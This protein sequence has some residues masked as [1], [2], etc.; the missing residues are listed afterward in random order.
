MITRRLEAA[1][2]RE[3]SASSN[4][5]LEGVPEA[6]R[7]AKQWKFYELDIDGDGLLTKEEAAI[8]DPAKTSPHVERFRL[9]DVD[10]NGSLSRKEYVEPADSKLEGDAK[11]AFENTAK[12]EF[13]MFDRDED[14]KLSFEEFCF[15][16]R[17]YLA[18]APKFRR[19]DADHNGRLTSR[20]FLS[21][22]SVSQQFKQRS[23]FFNFDA[24]NDQV[25]D[26]EEYTKRGQG[27]VVSLKN[28]YLARDADGDGRM[29]RAEFYREALG[30]AWEND[31]RKQAE[32]ADVDGDGFFSL[33]E[34]AVTRTGRFAEL[35]ALRDTNGDG[36]LNILEFLALLPK[37]QWPFVGRDFYAADLDADG[38][39][40]LEQEFVEHKKPVADRRT[41]PDPLVALATQRLE[42]I[43]PA[44]QAAD[45]DKDGRLSA[46]EWPQAKIDRLAPE[47][48]GIPFADWD[49][50]KDGFVT[51]EEQKE[52]VELAF[53]VALPGGL[54]LRKP[55]GHVFGSLFF[56]LDANKDGVASREEFI[57]GY[58]EKEKN[59]ERFKE[60]D[61]DGDG[62]LTM[63]EATA[64]AQM[65]TDVYFDFFKFD[66]DLDGGVTQNEA[67]CCYLRVGICERG[68]T[69]R[70]IRP[71]C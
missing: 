67:R 35:F 4:Y 11:A 36:F 17:S 40:S 41:R 2:P 51:E 66:A 27:V 5:Y 31:I 65:F 15:T 45:G 13:A 1:L 3:Q 43:A 70:G 22:Y 9:L 59:A 6:E 44:C 62:V 28:E 25:L 16:P 46:K 30:K 20:E 63:A 56:Q 19:L 42:Q 61:K 14:E 52:L 71:Q 60:W 53:G 12:L 8:A 64:V 18:A 57:A 54:L 69:G 50:D 55:G 33:L 21:P 23:E 10:K 39:L 68:E 24:D 34:F 37:E 47:L 26:L 38:R 48:M 29:S 49:R 32:L 7:S 58:W